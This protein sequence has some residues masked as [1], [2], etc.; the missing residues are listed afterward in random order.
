MA[1]E[2]SREDIGS[3][4]V[5]I[6]VDVSEALTGLKAVQREA[7][8]A[9]QALREMESYYESDG[10]R[11]YV[12]WKQHGDDVS[13]VKEVTISDIPTSILRRELAQRDAFIKI[14]EQQKETFK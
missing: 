14:D 5:K 7:R 2:K 1:D 9:T 10:K 3:L 11:F 8:K 12:S 13:E 6:D 4:K